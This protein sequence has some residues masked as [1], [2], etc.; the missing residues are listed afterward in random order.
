MELRRVG[1]VAARHAEI[2]HNELREKGEVE[3]DVSN[4]RGELPELFRIHAPADLWPPIMQPAHEG[5]HHSTDHDVMEMR[6]HKI[7]VGHV[8]IDG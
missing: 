2:A 8:H 4:Q 3:P 5:R 6:D 7:G 1:V